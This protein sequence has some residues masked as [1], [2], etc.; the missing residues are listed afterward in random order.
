MSE[1]DPIQWMRYDLD[2]RL[3]INDFVTPIYRYEGFVRNKILPRGTDSRNSELEGRR[4]LSKSAE[5][6]RLILDRPFQ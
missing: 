2:P 6:N 3:D 1:L 4:Q 5:I